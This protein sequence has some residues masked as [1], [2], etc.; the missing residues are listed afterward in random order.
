MGKGAIHSIWAQ[1]EQE[2]HGVALGESVFPSRRMGLRA[3]GSLPRVF[4]AGGPLKT[5]LVFRQRRTFCCEGIPPTPASQA[6]LI[7]PVCIL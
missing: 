1:R 5:Q 4:L 3:T 7:P 6:G 2:Q